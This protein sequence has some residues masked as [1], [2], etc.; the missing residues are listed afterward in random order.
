MAPA[1][2]QRTT[3]SM[4]NNPLY[5]LLAYATPLLLIMTAFRLHRRRRERTALAT[6]RANE[7]A[8]LTE[9]ASLHPLINPARCVGSG[10]CVSACPEGNV[11]AII[12]NRAQVVNPTHCIGHGACA[13]ACAHGAISLVFGTA[14]RGVD[15]PQVSADFESNVPGLYIAGELGGMGLVRNA[16]TQGQQAI[17][18]IARQ[19]KKAADGCY[20]VVIIGAGPAGIA[21]S[22]AAKQ[23]G[24]SYLTLEQESLGG[25]VANFP[26]NKIVMTAPV[27]LPLVGKVRFTEVSKETLLAFWHKIIDQH[28]LSIETRQRVESI[29]R[30]GDHFNVTT[31]Q[32]SYRA[33]HVLL[34]IGRRGTPRKLGVPGE[35]RSKVVYQLIDPEQYA[36]QRV[37]VVGGGDSAIE[38]ALSVAEQPGTDVTLSYRGQA[39]SRIKPGNRS[40]LEQAQSWPN[41]RLL[42]Q[43]NVQSI[44]AEDITIDCNGQAEQVAND[45]VIIAAGGILPT[46]FLHSI[47]IT[48]DT[49]YGTA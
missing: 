25:T 26:R 13:A 10:A 37:V 7:E 12:N 1:A 47:G 43:S 33:R 23:H 14:T 45:A 42:L 36:H 34:A 27:N 18:S 32:G 44:G 39:I 21:A 9:P 30:D 29:V 4:D 5:L 22:L 31:A 41:F 11:I 28:Q 24:L 15:I 19:K 6:L 3:D 38:A 8:G 20:D 17:G 46:A 16:V 35:E 49:K 48:T 2:E 40:R